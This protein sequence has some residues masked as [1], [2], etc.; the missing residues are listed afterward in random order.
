MIKITAMLLKTKIKNGPK[1]IPV[2]QNQYLNSKTIPVEPAF[3]SAICGLSGNVPM[4]QKQLKGKYQVRPYPS[5]TCV[6]E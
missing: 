5:V 1:I 4:A 6:S 2:K 3:S